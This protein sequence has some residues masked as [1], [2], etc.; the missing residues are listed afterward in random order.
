MSGTEKYLCC[1]CK[2]PVQVKDYFSGTCDT[3]IMKIQATEA[4]AYNRRQAESIMN[5]GDNTIW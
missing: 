5:G 4:K 1:E 3:C 2:K